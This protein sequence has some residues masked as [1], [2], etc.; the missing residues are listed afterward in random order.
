MTIEQGDMVRWKT[1]FGDRVVG[2][3][4]T[5]Q[6]GEGLCSTKADYCLRPDENETVVGIH[7]WPSSGGVRESP[8]DPDRVV[9]YAR[10]LEELDCE[11][12][13]DQMIC[14]GPD[15]DFEVES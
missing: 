11:E 7:H 12:S 1:R 14:H 10:N 15:R 13:N 4:Q 2:E 3:V 8:E 5:T 6:T 9:H